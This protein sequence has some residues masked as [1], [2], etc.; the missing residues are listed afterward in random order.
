MEKILK[1][2]LD[3]TKNSNTI[4]LVS[5]TKRLIT[6]PVNE[7]GLPLLY[8]KQTQEAARQ[9]RKILDSFNGNLGTAMEDQKGRPLDYGSEFLYITGIKNWFNHHKDKDRIVN[10]I[11]RVLHLPL[12]PIK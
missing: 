11:Q 1:G 9:K 8:F 10:I 5:I 6:K 12:S 3:W 7:F 2:K 4:W